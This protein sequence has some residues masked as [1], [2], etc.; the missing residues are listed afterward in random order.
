MS[1]FKY[2]PEALCLCLL[3]YFA[4]NGSQA[5]LDSQHLNVN[6][7]KLKTLE[8]LLPKHQIQLL[9]VNFS[10]QVHYDRFA[11]LDS[12][13]EQAAKDLENKT[14]LQTLIRNYSSGTS[15]YIQLVT[16]F[17]TSLRLISGYETSAFVVT[18]SVIQQGKI[19]VFNFLNNPTSRLQQ[20]IMTRLNS[21]DSTQLTLSELNHWNLFRLHSLFVLENYQ[22][23]A[24]QRQ[25]LINLPII[26]NVNKAVE[27]EYFNITRSQ[28]TLITATS[29]S[30]LCL[31]LLLIIVLKRQQMKLRQTSESLE[32]AVEI[33]S[34]FLANMS[35]EIRT[36]MTGIIGLIELTLKT[37]LTPQQRAYLEK[38]DFSANALL[39]IINDIL[40]FSKI[41]SGQ[42][43]IENITFDHIKLFDSLNIML[44]RVAEDKA[45][46]LIFDISPDVPKTITGDP[47]RVNQ[48]LLNLM[49]NAVKFTEH[50]HVILHVNLA[51]YDDKDW[52]CYQIEDTGIGLS[53]EQQLRLFKRFSQADHST[54]RKYGGTGLGLAIAKLLV[55]LMGGR[56]WVESEL[57]SGSK[58]NVALPLI[59][60]KSKIEPDSLPGLQMLLI[61]DYEVTQIVISK[62]ANHFKV[63]VDIATTISE[64]LT[65]VE[66]NH[67]D[68]ALVDWNLK[69][70]SGLDFI[71][72]MENHANRPDLL[73]ICSAYSKEYIE[74][75]ANV[76]FTGLFLPKPVTMESL[77]QILKIAKEKNHS[78]LDFIG[79]SNQLVKEVPNNQTTVS[80]LIQK[81]LLV[82]D[83]K[84]NQIVAM[85]LLQSLGLT[86]DLAENGKEALEAIEK[87]AYR[88]VLMDVQ[89]PVMDGIETTKVLRQT[90]EF[91]ELIIV[92]LTANVTEEEV[93]YY[94]KIGMNAHL[95][96]PYELDKIQ[97]LLSKY[98]QL[99]DDVE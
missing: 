95:G 77:Y 28:R 70:E 59:E 3:A 35:H 92:A 86:V 40:D 19:D 89:M 4:N 96:K 39:T 58:F 66:K 27:T 67:Y 53:T 42:L 10:D 60:L 81:I 11:Q 80:K 54:T 50:G 75:H 71:V 16:M 73:V 85:N 6:L 57:G 94:Q 38:I 37:T 30:I 63:D 13:I 8:M 26:S 17:K 31:L 83:N 52:I 65:L 45:I 34:Q 84:I 33:K 64:A 21:F 44:G 2:L 15:K 93:I 49:S 14:Q 9:N 47:V 36:P 20:A 61:E 32:H 62:M 88:V 25:H 22:Q 29:A 91:D 97:I 12:Q 18:N 79:K 90:Y 5:Y 51:Q 69:G 48:I 68:L 72:A 78:E 56:I 74:N 24:T 55:E 98:Y 41:E 46:E 87:Y 1:I 43:S 82:E 99:Y 23:S 7:E 76:A